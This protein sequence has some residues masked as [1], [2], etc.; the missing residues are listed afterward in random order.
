M[1]CHPDY[2]SY[3]TQ[4]KTIF[5]GIPC[6]PPI[7]DAT[8]ALFTIDRYPT[9]LNDYLREM[10]TR[11]IN[12]VISMRFDSTPDTMVIDSLRNPRR[13]FDVFLEEPIN[14]AMVTSLVIVLLNRDSHFYPDMHSNTQKC[15]RKQIN[16]HGYL[17]FD[18]LHRYYNK[19]S[20]CQI[21]FSASVTQSPMN[22]FSFRPKAHTTAVKSKR[23]AKKANNKRADAPQSGGFSY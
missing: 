12:Y 18:L 10:Q 5:N 2:L 3:I 19:Y 14:K 9:K 4:V 23:H 7:L 8:Q 1:N 17:H 20:L 6:D 21:E 15:I 11:L 22:S 16:K 13:S